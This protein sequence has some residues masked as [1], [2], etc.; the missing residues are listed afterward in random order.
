MV[1]SSMERKNDDWMGAT[2]HSIEVGDLP[3]SLPQV[4]THT[5]THTQRGK[6][7]IF[8]FFISYSLVVCAV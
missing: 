3:L 4:S 7:G 8:N 6:Y 5:H 2:E 1:V